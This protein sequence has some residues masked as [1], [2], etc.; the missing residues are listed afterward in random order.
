MI[1]QEQISRIKSMMGI[2]S[3]KITDIKGTPLYHITSTD[4]GLKIIESDTLLGFEQGPEQ[5]RHDKRLAS[6]KEKKTISFTRNKNW[7]PKSMSSIGVFGD[8]LVQDL[9]ITFVLD[10]EKLKTKYIVEP[11]D[12]EGSVGQKITFFNQRPKPLDKGKQEYEFEYE[13]RVL[14]DKIYPLRKYIIEIIYTG[15]DPE[16]KK[17]IENYLN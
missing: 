4:R 11:F 3:E 14:S 17:I 13:E 10:K 15:N 1:L 5:R 16:V 8:Q 9:D 12:W 6:S 2:I 7:K